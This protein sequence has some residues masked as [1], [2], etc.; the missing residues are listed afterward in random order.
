MTND[1]ID[2]RINV[3]NRAAD[4]TLTPAGS[5]STGGQGSGT[6]DYSA[7][8][9]ILGEQS[10]NNLNGGLQYLI[11]TNAGSD[12]ISVFDTRPDG[13][14][15]LVDIEPARRR[16][17]SRQMACSCPRT[18]GAERPL[19][20]LL[21]RQHRQRQVRLYDQLSERRHLE[22]PRTAGRPARAAQ[23]DRGV[24]GSARATRP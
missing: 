18:G 19:G 9:L 7:N 12:T 6:F 11:A 10:P 1:G 21:D 24:I 13:S 5:F 15:E 17:T 16:T 8:G 3:L 2:N 22:L 20:H 23:S 14:L 4:G